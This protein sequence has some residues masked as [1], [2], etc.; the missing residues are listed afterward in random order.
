MPGPARLALLERDPQD[1]IACVRGHDVTVERFTRD[2]QALLPQLPEAGYL[3][4][5]L[6]DRYAFTVAFVATLAAGKIN[7]LPPNARTAVQTQLARRF[8]QVAVLHDGADVAAGLEGLDLRSALTPPELAAENS[9]AITLARDDSAP[10]VLEADASALG[11]IAFTSGSTGEAQPIAKTVGMF[12]GATRAYRDSIVSDG[13]HLVATVPAQHM[14]GLEL[15]ALQPLWYP[16]SFTAC[17][18][19]FPEDVRKELER[20]PAPRVLITTPL[21]LR[22][23]LDSG[24]DFPELERVVCATAPLGEHLARLAEQRLAAPVIDVFG[25]SEAGCVATRRLARESAWTLLP[26]FRLLRGDS[27]DYRVDSV[28]ADAPAPMADQV[29]LLEGGRFELGGRCGDQ[30]NVAGKRGSLGEITARMLEVAGVEDAVVFLPP[31][32]TENQRPAALFSGSADRRAI[33]KHLRD[34]LDDVFVPRP[35][36]QVERLPRTETSKLPRDE[37]LALFRQANGNP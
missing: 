37:V 22:A 18:P 28:H 19:L 7:L 25:Y 29:H 15:T 12:R 6:Q 34:Y 13:A 20:V 5:L 36:L 26:G 17:K 1:L 35:L 23:L 31:T 14:Y 21:H 33:R 11:A 8:D 2:V 27:G 10:A 3:F 9:P 32:A 4:N 30:I 24:L 16:V